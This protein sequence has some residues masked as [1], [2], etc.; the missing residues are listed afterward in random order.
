MYWMTLPLKKYFQFS[1]RSRRKE[2]WMFALLFWILFVIAGII[3][4]MLG[5]GAVET[6]TAAASYSYDWKVENGPVMIAVS[7]LFFFPHLAVSVRRLHDT[8]RTGWWLLILLVPL[9]GLVV[10]FVF[11]CLD[12]TIG[13]NRFGPD[14]KAGEPGH[15]PLAA[16][17]AG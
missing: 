11:L 5:F 12:G 13:P 3:D 8:N 15:P 14:P 7:L 17:P 9:V 16:M 6:G 2:Y 1:G 4:T 10:M